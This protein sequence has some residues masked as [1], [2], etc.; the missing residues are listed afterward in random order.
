MRTTVELDAR[1]AVRR[2]VLSVQLREQTRGRHVDAELAF[3]LESRLADRDSYADLLLHLRGFYGPLERALADVDG[4][5]LLTP[6]I[7]PTDWCRAGLLDDDLARLARPVAADLAGPEPGRLLSIEDALGT[8]YVLAGSALGGRL[9]ARRA[10]DRLGEAL[11]VAFFTGL[12][13]P[14]LG[15]AW[16]GLTA[17]LDG[18]G[19]VSPAAGSE[20][21]VLAAGRAFAV[22]THRLAPEAKL[23]RGSPLQSLR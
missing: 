23:G 9:I 10:R 18:F 6:P 21:V 22:L 14:D 17:T 20:R 16:R 8:L 3:D 5:H 1:A 19:A 11:P 2:P 4:W 12:G 13:R 15:P 7:E